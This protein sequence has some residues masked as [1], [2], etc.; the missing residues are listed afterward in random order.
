[1]KNIPYFL[2]GVLIGLLAAGLL[3]LTISPPRGEPV[4]LLPTPTTGS[5]TVHVAGAVAQPGVY[6]LP[7]G[8]RV[9][10]AIQAAGGFLTSADKDEINLAALLIDGMQIS[11]TTLGGE[12][13][14]V[15]G[16]L[17]INTATFEELDSLPGIGATA[18]Q[19]IINYRLM[20]GPFA[21]IESILDV[22]GIGPST[23]ERIKN[24]ITVG[25]SP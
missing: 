16:R 12:S 5:V 24:L 3:W 19:N 20:H 11:V 23:Y 6:S 21:S 7:V 17:N 15:E 25:Y 1:M 14:A 4:T 8:S 9:D 10:S 13:H 2:A 22:P 18:A